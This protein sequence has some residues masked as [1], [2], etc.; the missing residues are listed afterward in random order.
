MAMQCV[1]CLYKAF[2]LTR[3]KVFHK[4]SNKC[5]SARRIQ[6]IRSLKGQN[7]SRGGL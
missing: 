1:Y 5:A 2:E 6:F 3:T 4:K 7:F